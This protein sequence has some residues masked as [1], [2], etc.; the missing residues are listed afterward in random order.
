M[1][2]EVKNIFN[3]IISVSQKVIKWHQLINPLLMSVSCAHLKWL[4]FIWQNNQETELHH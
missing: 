2:L 3:D 1:A 4:K